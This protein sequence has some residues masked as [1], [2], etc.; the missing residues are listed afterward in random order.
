MCGFNDLLGILTGNFYA[1]DGTSHLTYQQFSHGRINDE[2]GKIHLF[3]WLDDQACDRLLFSQ[4]EETH[5]VSLCSAFGVE[6]N[7]IKQIGP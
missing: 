5:H 3:I 7:E 2:K 6:K 4:T 1:N